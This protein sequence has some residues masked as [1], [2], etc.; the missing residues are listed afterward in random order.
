MGSLKEDLCGQGVELIETHTAWVFLG[1]ATV[2]KVKKPVDYGFLNFSTLERRKAACEAEVRLNARLAPDVYEGVVPV[3]LDASKAHHLGGEG[4][5]VDYAVKM[6]RL[7]DRV[8]GDVLLA[9]DRLRTT[10]LDALA[11]HLAAFHGALGATSAVAAPFGS[12]EA[13]ERNVVENFRQS[14]DAICSFVTE[15]E[16]LQI[17]RQQTEFLKKRGALLARR[18]ERGRVRDGH[19]DLR[20]EHV[21]FESKGPPTI[22]DCLEFDDRFRYADVCSDIAF[23]SMDLRRLGRAD[24][25]EHFVASYARASGDYELY[26][27][28]DFYEGYRAYVRGKVALLLAADRSAPTKTRD[29]A[30]KQARTFFLLSLVEGKKSLLAP[31]LVAVGGVIASGKSTV[32]ERIGQSLNAPVVGSD[33]TRK[34]LLGVEATAPVHE[35]A[36]SGAYSREFSEKVYDEL[37][38]RAGHVLASGRSVVVDASFG[39]RRRR[40]RVRE[41]ARARGVRF[42]FVEC[43]APVA[44]C[45]RR[46]EERARSRSVSDGRL[47]IFD[48]F[49]ARFDEVSELPREEHVVLDTTRP[50]EENMRVFSKELPGWPPGFVG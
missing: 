39:A 4:S 27:L 13:I 30:A 17:E 35:S 20:L 42:V 12:K 7:P 25:A 43:R 2:I 22:I 33:L 3:T 31:A 46:L 5:V 18:I 45:K 8:R 14:R 38:S 34:N 15:S 28:L 19:G 11:E 10:E 48:E 16:A 29:D 24:L 49:V 50:L 44:E 21:Y 23:L 40:E 6:R 36:W 9:H 32:A 47:E 26:E 41:L 1:E 37:F